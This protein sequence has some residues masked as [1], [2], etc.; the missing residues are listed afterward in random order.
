MLHSPCP[1]VVT[2]HDLVDAQAPQRV[3]AHRPAPAP[4]PPRGAARRAR[5]RADA[6][7]RRATPSTRL[8]LERERIVVIPEAADAAM[9]PRAPRRSPRR[10]RASACPSATCVWVGGLQHPDPRKHVAELAAARRASCR[11][12]SSARAGP[13]A[14][15]LPDVILTGQVS[16][17]ELA[18]I[19]SGAHALVLPVRRRG[20]RPARR[21]G[22]RLRHAGRGVRGRRRCARCSATARRSSS[23][24][25]WRRS[26]RPRRRARARRRRR[27]RGRWQDAAR[28]TW[29]VYARP[30]RARARARPTPERAAVRAARAARGRRD[31]LEPQ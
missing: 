30:R 25:T 24:A 13:W 9:Y 1:M 12:C 22:A 15:E 14:H 21:R 3:P 11:S 26:S 28:A 8:A 27:R 17:D 5:D 4:A 31:G 10:E 29:A 20:L 2:L 7:R 19:Y 23:A 16:D 6:G 18:A